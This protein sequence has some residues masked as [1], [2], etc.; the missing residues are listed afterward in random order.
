MISVFIASNYNS[1]KTSIKDEQLVKEKSDN[2]DNEQ[3]DH[4]INNQ[5]DNTVKIQQDDSLNN[6]DDIAIKNQQ[7]DTII[8][9]EHIQQDDSTGISN[10]QDDTINNQED[11]QQED[12]ISK[13]QEDTLDSQQDDTN[14]QQ[15]AIDVLVSVHNTVGLADHSKSISEVDS[16][17]RGLFGYTQLHLAASSGNAELV[18]FLLSDSSNLNVNNKTVDGGYTPLHLAASAGHTNCV[19]KLLKSHNTSLHVTDA[20]GRTP[21]QTA[22]QHNKTDVAKSLRSHGK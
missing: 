6:N 17:S 11:I 1:N 3:Q 14:N 4:T 13:Q 2:D 16:R 8:N 9:Q 21:L 7:D 19:K 12:S 20:F 15:K 10:Q 5:E 18:D 22:E